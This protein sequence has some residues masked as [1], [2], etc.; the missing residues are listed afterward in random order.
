MS[1]SVLICVIF[2]CENPAVPAREIFI[3]TSRNCLTGSV[4]ELQYSQFTPGLRQDRQV[5]QLPS[6]SPALSALTGQT[7]SVTNLYQNTEKVGW[8][9]MAV[10][11]INTVILSWRRSLTSLSCITFQLDQQSFHQVIILRVSAHY[12]PINI[13]IFSHNKKCPISI[14]KMRPGL[15]RYKNREILTLVCIDRK[16]TWLSF[17]FV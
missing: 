11:I 12:Q 15:P 3:F 1:L 2:L 17:F 7:G 13:S 5:F 9:V 4:L 16:A 6:I 14:S 10:D 8:S